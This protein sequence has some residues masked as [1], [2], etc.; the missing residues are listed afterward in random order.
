M[1]CIDGQDFGSGS[2]G[3]FDGGYA[4]FGGAEWVEYGGDGVYEESDGAL[5]GFRNGR[6]TKN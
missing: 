1:I 5:G 6:N 3:V 4:E 2:A